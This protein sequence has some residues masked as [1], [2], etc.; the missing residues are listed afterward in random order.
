V[1]WADELARG[2][3][4]SQPQVVNDSKTPSGSI[5]ISSLRGPII[6]DA[7][8]RALGEAGV[9]VRF[10]FGIDDMDPMD[11]QSMRTDEHLA[12]HMGRPLA[13][14]PAPEAGGTDFADLHA[15]RFLATFPDLGIHPSER[16]RTR[17]LYREGRMDRSIDLVLRRAEVVREVLARVANV[18]KDADY[19]ALN[20]ICENCGRLG[21]TKVTGYDGRAVTYECRPDLVTWA[22]GCGHRGTVSPFGGR[23]KL[24]FVEEWCAKWDVFGVTIE[25]CG[26]DLSTAGGARDRSEALYREVWQKEPPLNVP[27][28][29]VTVAGRKMSTS[30]AQ[31][32]RHLG[33][34][35][36]EIVELLTGEIVRFLMLRTRPHS[37]I[38]FDPSG[39]RIPRLFDE[40]DRA[41]DAYVNDPSSDL[42]R[43]YALSQRSTEVRTGYR[44]PFSLLAN[45][46]QMPHLDPQREA[47]R[48]IGR[49][50]TA[51]EEGELERRRRVAATW[52]ERWAPEEAKFAVSQTLPQA[53]RELTGEQREL[54][55]RLLPFVGDSLNA[56]ELTSKIYEL[57]RELGMP[58]GA[59]AFAAVYLA[60]IGKP[61][62]PQAGPLLAALDRDFVRRRLSEAVAA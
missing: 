49:T 20:V 19:Y 59:P 46:L 52:L 48:L 10:T 61:R 34:A 16:Y 26:K 27:Y 5:P 32:W 31:T 44:V 1:F 50:L 25:G 13:Q 7:I 23:G 6:H 36:H 57:S 45:W 9:D 30:H 55:R 56:A 53:A 17:D 18:K 33:A 35:A 21:T 14:I 51:W 2:T 3:R 28:E 22:V 37:T 4:A 54:L 40:Y 8:A 15:G 42:G 39:D 12:P 60:F 47:E 43:V 29:F 41:A 38:E 11:S 62:G 24:P 58:S